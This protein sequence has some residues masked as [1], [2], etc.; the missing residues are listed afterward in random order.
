M[1]KVY[2]C[3]WLGGV[4]LASAG[5]IALFIVLFIPDINI[6]WIILSPVILALY[7]APAVF[8]FW[9]WKKHRSKQ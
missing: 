1:N 7:Q 6:Y 2:S 3:L 5:G 8:L 4:F 9:L